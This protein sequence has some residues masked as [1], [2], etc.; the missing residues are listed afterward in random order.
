[1]GQM[2]MK[3]IT[4]SGVSSL[5]GSRPARETNPVLVLACL[6]HPFHFRNPPWAAQLLAICSGRLTEEHL[7]ATHLRL[8]IWNVRLSW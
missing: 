3:E 1:M 2:I 7:P 6:A 8:K 5:P 4:R